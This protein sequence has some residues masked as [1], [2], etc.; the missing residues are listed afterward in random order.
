MVTAVKHEW[1][2]V[3]RQYCLEIDEDLLVEIY[4][5]LGPGEISHM[6]KNL[7]EGLLD[8]E[9][10]IN[11]AWENDVDLDW[12]HQY[13]DC[14]TDRKGGYDVT[15]ELGDEDSYHNEPEP[16]PPTHKCTKCKWTGAS[17]DADW[18]YEDENGNDLE[19]AKKVCPYCESDTE[20]TEYGVQDEKERQER[21][22][23][24][25]QEDA[26]V[27]DLETDP[28]E[29]AQALE[30]LKR[31]FETLMD[32][33]HKCTECDWQ[34]NEDECEKEGIC[35]NCCAHIEKVSND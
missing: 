14:W 27:E 7:E 31:E 21:M 2:Q 18:K 35:P 1:H 17:Y 10:V 19:E 30:E 20:L 11:D 6:L 16:T 34:G 13:D 28:L 25:A 4:P 32:G 15:Y 12:E 26:E 22:A 24:W 3:D 5:D 9:D 23:R 33:T 8:I 29:L